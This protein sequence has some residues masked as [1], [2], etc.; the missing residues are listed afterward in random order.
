LELKV[1][2]DAE[3]FDDSLAVLDGREEEVAAKVG[4]WLRNAM[5][6]SSRN[7]M[8]TGSG[9]SP[10]TIT[11]IKHGPERTRLTYA[12]TSSGM[13]RAGSVTP[14]RVRRPRA[15]PPRGRVGLGSV[16]HAF[17]SHPTRNFDSPPSS[18]RPLVASGLCLE[19]MFNMID[20][21]PGNRLH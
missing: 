9:P 4:N 19:R 17:G 8:W 7:T 20:R 16:A 18:R 3:V 14:K 15:I 5:C 21:L 2:A 1:L 11:Q 10:A 6:L 13:R 12:S